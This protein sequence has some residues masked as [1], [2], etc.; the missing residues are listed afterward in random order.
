MCPSHLG[1]SFRFEEPMMCRFWSCRSSSILTCSEIAL[2][3]DILIKCLLFLIFPDFLCLVAVLGY[4]LEFV[5]HSLPCWTCSILCSIV[6]SLL[7]AQPLH[8]CHCMYDYGCNNLPY[9]CHSYSFKFF[10]SCFCNYAGSGSFYLLHF[11]YM[12][13]YIVLFVYG[14]P[15]KYLWVGSPSKYLLPWIFPDVP[16]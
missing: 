10:V 5:A 3:F 16:L 7:T 1:G 4:I 9:C 14:F 13:C 15:P 11:C 12:V 2:R 6:C 8:A